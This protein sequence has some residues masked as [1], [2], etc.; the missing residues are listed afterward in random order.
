VIALPKLPESL[1]PINLLP[2]TG[3][4]F[5]KIILRIIQRHIEGSNILNPC[6]FG[7]RARHIT[8]LQ[9]KRLADHVTLDFNMSTA[10]VFLDIEKA[11]NT[12]WHSGFLYK[13]SE[14]HFSSSL[15]KLINSLLSHRKFR[16]MVEGE[17]ST[18]PPPRNIQSG[19]PQG[20]VLSPILYNLYIND[21]PQTLGVYL[22]LFADDTCLYSTDREEFYVLRKLQCGLT[23]ME[24]WCERWNIKINEEDSGHLL[25]LSAQTGRSLS[26]YHVVIF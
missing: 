9:C 1:R 2:I 15:I 25:L 12:T 13:F 4:L 8:M 16:D 23:A 11:S 3:K 21:K 7:F 14:L 6:Q 18:T 5:E 26:I 22:A 19:V 10:A 17:L 24:S 20:S